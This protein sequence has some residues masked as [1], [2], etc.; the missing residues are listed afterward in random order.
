MSKVLVTK[1]CYCEHY[2]HEKTKYPR[3]GL[4]EVTFKNGE[5]VELIREWNNFYGS[6]YKVKKSDGT[7]GDLDVTNGKLI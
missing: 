7:T 2:L 3:E 4:V 6:Y 5:E 1:D